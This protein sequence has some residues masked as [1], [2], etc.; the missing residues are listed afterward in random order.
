[1]FYTDRPPRFARKGIEF[2]AFIFGSLWTQQDG[3]GAKV[4][5][6]PGFDSLHRLFYRYIR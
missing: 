3:S 5:N 4:L 1:M 6:I 2:I